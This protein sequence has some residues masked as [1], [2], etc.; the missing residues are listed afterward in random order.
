MFIFTE[1]IRKLTLKIMKTNRWIH[2]AL[3]ILIQ[4]DTSFDLKHI[5][6][7]ILTSFFLPTDMMFANHNAERVF[8]FFKF[9]ARGGV[10]RAIWTHFSFNITV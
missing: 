9:K 10:I 7:A 5:Y 1:H 3:G 4:Y 8:F 2:A 6:V